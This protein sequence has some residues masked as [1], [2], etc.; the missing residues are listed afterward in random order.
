MKKIAILLA[1]AT[2]LA[3]PFTATAQD[4]EGTT[5]KDAYRFVVVPKVVH[6]WF[7]KVNE[8]AQAAAAAIKAQT[9]SDVEVIYSAPQAADVVQQNQIIDS[10]LATQPDGLALDLLDPSGNRASLEEAQN[11]KIPLVIF[12]SVPPEGMA[13]PYIGS[14]FCEQAKIAARRLVEVLGGEG[15]VAIMQGV[16]TAPNHSIRAECHRQVFAE[17]PGIKVVAEG[18]DN[19]SIETAQQ[20]AAAI[21]QAN[22]NLKGWVASDAAG[23]IGIGQAI[24]EAGKQ[25]KVTLVGLDNLPEMLDMIRDG[26][27]DSSSAS[28][29]ELQGYWSVMLLWAQATGAKVPGYLDTGNAFLTKENVGG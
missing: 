21:M 29:P 12:D 24:V 15:E 14:D 11:Q 20:Q 28:Q 27:A 23:P 26:V 16:P 8:G 6:P 22:P 2:A 4:A 9:G 25:G 3:L 1:C 7:D 19:D 5:K 18:I 10:A 17:H 13:I